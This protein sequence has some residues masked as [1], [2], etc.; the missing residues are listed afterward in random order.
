[1]ADNGSIS[2]PTGLIQFGVLGVIVFLMIF[3]YLWAKPAVDQ[4]KKDKEKAEADRD[5]LI[6]IY[7]SQV[8]PVLAKLTDVAIPAIIQIQ[9]DIAELERRAPN[10]ST[11]GP[12][13][14][15]TSQ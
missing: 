6:D 3:G 7:Q 14:R 4:L 11:S 9:I 10:S 2:D 15:D 12:Q 5:E 1:M 8:I 13:V